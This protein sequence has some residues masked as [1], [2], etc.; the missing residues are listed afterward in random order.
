MLLM[1]RSTSLCYC[2]ITLDLLIPEYCPRDPLS[3]LQKGIVKM[4]RYIL[5]LRKNRAYM[6]EI[7]KIDFC[8]NILAKVR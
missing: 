5:N 7:N 2:G 3:F 4:K 8:Q 6:L 1:V